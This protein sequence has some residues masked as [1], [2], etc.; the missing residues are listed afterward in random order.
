SNDVREYLNKITPSE[1]MDFVT[2]GTDAINRQKRLE[3]NLVNAQITVDNGSLS[4]TQLLDTLPSEKAQLDSYIAMKILKASLFMYNSKCVSQPGISDDDCR[5]FLETKPIPQGST[6]RAECERIL[7]GPRSGHHAFR[8]LLPP[9]YKNGLHEISFQMFE[10]NKQPAAWPISMALYD[11]DDS[12]VRTR[13]S[14][15][16]ESGNLNLVLAQFA[17]F[18]E[19]DLSKTVAQSMNNGASIECCNRDQNKLLPRHHHP[20]CAPILSKGR[21]DFHN[22]LNYVRSALAIGENC[23]FGAAEQLNQ[24]TGILD[25]SQLYG[26]TDSV[27]RKMRTLRNGALKSSGNGKLLSVISGDEG[28]TFCAWGSGAN[29]TNCFVAGDSRVNSNPLSILV[30]TIFMRNHNRIAAELL[31]RNKGWSDEQLFQAAKVVN[32]DIYRRLIMKEWLT[33]VLGEASAANVLAASPATDGQQ[34]PEVSNEFGVAAIRFYFSMLPNVL[35]NLAPDNEVVSHTASNQGYIF[36]SN[37]LPLTKLFELKNEIYKPRLQYTS[38]KLNE[39]LQSLLHE[40]AMKMDSSY[41]DALVWHEPTKPAHADVLAFDIQRGR[42]H[43]L[44]PYYKYLEICNRNKKITSW[45]DFEDFIPKELVDKLKTIYN[46]WTHVDLIVGGISE[47][48]FNGTVG[49]TFSCILAEQ[50]SK[51]QQRHKQQQSPEHT[52]LL[53]AY[54]S[55][56]GTQL[57]CLNSNLMAVPENIFRLQ[58]DSNRLVNCNDVE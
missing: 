44:Q 9:H 32:V 6:L 38:K 12:A 42:D 36:L 52:A 54:S 51:I 41:V 2:A 21:N 5:T 4:H 14:Q 23:N 8:R 7:H 22:C 53:E 34:L 26:F 19:H 45:S 50:F 27:E 37:I 57:L 25:L 29:G 13:T 10:V 1:W 17:Q 30:Y 40:R 15:P 3:E 55:V 58:S 35:H 43:G 24:A 49:P 18:V 56:N 33:Q 31:A 20:M 48:T 39:I 16:D 46:S 47:H 28:H 11:Q